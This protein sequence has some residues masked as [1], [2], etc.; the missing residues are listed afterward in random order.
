MADVQTLDFC[1]GDGKRGKRGKRGPRGPA[2]PAGPSAGGLLMFSGTVLSL[3][4]GP[5]LVT[6]L[7]AAGPGNTPTTG[8]TS[9]PLAIARNFVNIET[10][11]VANGPVPPD[12]T[13][14]FDLIKNGDLVTPVPG[15][16]ITYVAGE[17]GIKSAV[18]G[19]VAF[20][21]GDTF[22]L[23]VTISPTDSFEINPFVSA[24]IGL[25]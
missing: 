18:A 16:S 8:E 17:T 4:E 21:I 9:Y 24:T 5:S 23:R 20:A 15:F 3:G 7:G 19:P 25:E 6:F 11:L 10:N 13:L 14:T 1:D 2:G 22:D 12:T